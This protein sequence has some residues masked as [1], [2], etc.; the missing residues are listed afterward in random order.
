[1]TDWRYMPVVPGTRRP[2]DGSTPAERFARGDDDEPAALARYVMPFGPPRR[3]VV[4]PPF[5]R[6]TVP[7][8]PRRRR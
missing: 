6:R 1:V 5:A 8:Y 4:D 3:V 7:P 2:D